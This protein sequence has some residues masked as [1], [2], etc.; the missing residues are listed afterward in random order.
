MDDILNKETINLIGRRID[1]LNEKVNQLKV[2]NNQL[3]QEN[4][5]LRI[6]LYNHT[7]YVE[8]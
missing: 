1:E 3:R 4:T 6:A 7:G 5:K 8:C 2:E